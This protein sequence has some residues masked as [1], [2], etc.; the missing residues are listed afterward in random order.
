MKKNLF[1]LSFVVLS[2]LF[3]LASCKDDKEEPELPPVVEDILAQYSGDKVKLT[4]DGNTVSGDAQVDLLQMDDKSLT[5]KLSNVIPGVKE[6]LIPNADFE[7]VTRSAYISKLDGKAS[8]PVTGYDVTFAG[9]V[10]EGV[11]TAT[12]TATEIKGD[13]IHAKNAGLTSKTFKGKMTIDVSNI[14]TPIEMEQRVY[15]S[16]AA[17]RDTSCIKLQINNFAFQGIKLGDISLNN[18][19]VVRRGEQDGK[20]IYG[21]KAENQEMTLEVVG[22]V[23]I[24]VQGTIIGDNMNLNLGVNAVS[25]GLT[26]NV[27]FDGKIVEESADTKTE[28]TV[29]G[30]AVAEGVTSSGSTY[31]FKVWES[32]PAEKLML[33]PVVKIPETAVLD[34]VVIY[35]VKDKKTE[36]IDINT[37]IDFSK[38]GESDYVGYHITPE[39]VRYPAKKMLKIVRLAEVSTVYDMTEWVIDPENDKPTPKGLV[40]SNLAATFFPMFGIDVPVPV[41]KADDNSAEITTSRTVAAEPNGLVP[42]VTAGT[43]FIGEFKVDIFNTLKST[44]FGIPYNNKPVDFKI[45]YKFT[46]GTTFYKTIQNDEGGNITEVMPNEKDECSINAY[47]YEVSSYAETLDGTN[48]NTSNKVILKAV[49]ADGSAKADYT[50]VT[51]PFTEIGN[52]S[53]DPAKKYKLAIVCSS[54]KR[55]DEFMGADGSKLWVKYLE[56]TTR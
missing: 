6:F 16:T 1:Y 28:I 54:S 40:N 39:D 46:P 3:S 19:L 45:T 15:T 10:D 22:D 12:I 42:G 14:P 21:F 7:A 53:Y 38:F 52:G 47:L 9:T 20:P 25:V 43:L 37:P 24:D 11:L 35:Y 17:N 41:V 30:D 33:T 2:L 29:T 18:I 32:T 48:I 56:V 23:M 4:V 8:D 13:S 51:I 44:H 55:G 26:V 31:T 50:S 5:I 34:S 36:K 27:G 49:L